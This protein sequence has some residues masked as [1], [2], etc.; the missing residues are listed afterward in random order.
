[1]CD[2]RDIEKQYR[3]LTLVLSGRDNVTPTEANRKSVTK[4]VT[5]TPAL[6]FPVLI[7]LLKNQTY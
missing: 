5:P 4:H 2:F 7:G 3:I 1:M 6:Q